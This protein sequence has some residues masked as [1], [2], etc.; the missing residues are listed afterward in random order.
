MQTC[1]G[2]WCWRLGNGCKRTVD[3]ILRACLPG[4]G[5]SWLSGGHQG[6]SH[7]FLCTLAAAPFAAHLWQTIRL[8]VMGICGTSR[9]QT[10]HLICI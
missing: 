4:T 5:G 2:V 7:T 3:A 1:R 8:A 9:S 6:T 10:D